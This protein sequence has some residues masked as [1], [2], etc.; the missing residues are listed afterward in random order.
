VHELDPLARQAGRLNEVRWFHANFTYQAG[1]WKKP[2]RVIAKVEWHPGE[3]YPRVGFIVTNL[4]RPA[5]RVVAFYNHRGTCE[6]YI[7]EG[8][9]RSNGRGCRAV[10]SPPTRFAYSSMLLPTADVRGYP[11]VD[12][13]AAGTA[14]ASKRF[15]APTRSNGWFDRLLAGDA[16]F[17]VA[18]DA[19]KGRS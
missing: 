15:S 19:P 3:L 8:K 17:Y 1:S 10:P 5:E 6:Q 9:G 12:R 13:P 16:R 4:A 2:R 11:D 7:K 14:R 18:Q